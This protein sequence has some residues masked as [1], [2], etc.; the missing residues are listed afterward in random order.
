MVC[1]MLSRASSSSIVIPV[2]NL[3]YRSQSQW[4]KRPCQHPLLLERPSGYR[5]HRFARDLQFFALVLDLRQDMTGK[6]GSVL[7]EILGI[8]DQRN[9][10]EL[11]NPGLDIGA[12]NARHMI[13][14]SHSKG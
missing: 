11:G 4:P 9:C 13:G 8:A 10:D 7:E 14:G 2:S 12:Q 6:Q 1:R 5:T 3:D